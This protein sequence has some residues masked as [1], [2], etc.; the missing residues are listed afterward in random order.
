MC[1]RDRGDTALKFR[2]ASLY[3]RYMAALK[4]E[5]F[6][7][8]QLER[9]IRLF[10]DLSLIHISTSRTERLT[11]MAL[12]SRRKRRISPMIMGWP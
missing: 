7:Q 9:S 3:M 4:D 12:L 11:R 2:I 10:E 8:K 6:V 1:I 5:A